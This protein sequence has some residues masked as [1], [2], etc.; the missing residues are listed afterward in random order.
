M[1]EYVIG[2]HTRR[3]SATGREL[4]SGERFYT[5]LLD[6]GQTWERKDFSAEAW[7]GPPPG[8]FSYWTGRVPAAQDSGRPRIDDEL[9]EEC[10]HRLADELEPAKVKFRYV[11]A[12]LLLR[13]KR[14]KLEQTVVAEGQEQL[15]MVC[16]RT[17]AKYQVINPGLSEDAMS[18]VQDEVFKVL[19]WS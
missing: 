16:P 9:L 1:T 3:C 19:G 11:T 14:L 12:L 6:A 2:P 7:Q 5:A 13:R 15:V 4:K 17:G 18:L 8:A 10:F